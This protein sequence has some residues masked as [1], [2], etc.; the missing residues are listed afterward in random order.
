MKVISFLPAATSMMKEM[1][2]DHL[3]NGVTFECPSD[4]PKIVRSYLEGHNYSSEEI[5]RIVT[6]AS[7]QGKSLYYVDME[8]LESISPDLVFTQDVCDVC[9]IGTSYVE[10]AIGSLSKQPKVVPLIPRR[11]RD[12]LQNAHTIAAELGEEQ[13]GLDYLAR[14]QARIDA[15]TDRLRQ[16]QADMKR[17]M[18]MEWLDPIYNCGH[19]IPDQI[20]LAGG[21]DMLANP[22]GYSVVTPWEKVLQYDPEVLVIAPCGFQVERSVQ[23]IDRLTSKPGWNDLLAVKNKAVYL[24]DA[25]LFTQPSTTLVDGVELLAA[26]FH[27]DLFDIPEHSKAKVMQLR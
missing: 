3:L 5:D 23:E 6:E 10:R 13:V 22:A 17:V 15:V 2:L 20:A 1:K 25:H 18:I 11:F 16:H 12:V 27:P 4:K 7:D 19:W 14:L 21:T 24:A 9:Q 26:L 8:L